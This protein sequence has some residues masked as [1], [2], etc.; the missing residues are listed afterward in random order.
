MSAVLLYFLSTNQSKTKELQLNLPQLAALCLC[1]LKPP[2]SS[3]LFAAPYWSMCSCFASFTSD[4]WKLT[5]ATGTD[6]DTAAFASHKLLW[7]P[8]ESH[9]S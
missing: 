7:R 1:Q 9:L 8:R 2:A 5:K 6:P 3:I 4:A